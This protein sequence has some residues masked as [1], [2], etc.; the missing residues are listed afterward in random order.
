MWITFPMLKPTLNNLTHWVVGVGPLVRQMADEIGLIALVNRMLTWDPVRTKVSPG[1][2]FFAMV[3]DILMGHSPLYRVEDRLAS[4]DVPL[5]L[6]EER[7][8]EDFSDDSLGRAQGGVYCLGGASVCARSTDHA[9]G[10]ERGVC[11]N[12]RAEDVL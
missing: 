12:R 8:A 3:L 1:E 10:E 2:R 4:T 6:G 11:T 7:T 9:V 5:L